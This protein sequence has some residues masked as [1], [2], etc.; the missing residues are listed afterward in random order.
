MSPALAD[1]SIGWVHE[2][3]P[4]HLTLA[5]GLALSGG[6]FDAPGWPDRNLHTDIDAA[7]DA[8]LSAVVASGTQWGG[9]VVGMLVDLFGTHWFGSGELDVK[10]TRSVQV[11]ETLVPRAKLEARESVD[12]GTR[13]ELEVQCLN[14]AGQH[15]LTGRAWC[16]VPLR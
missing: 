14:E 11:G 12:G 2:G 7:N 15:V 16:T 9:Y 5:R 1:A 10:I 3:R 8:G 6:P 4:R 13:Y